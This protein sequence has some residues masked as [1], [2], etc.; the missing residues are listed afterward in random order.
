[1]L[2]EGGSAIDAAIAA[3]FC[4][5][6]AMPQS[7]GLGGGFVMMIYSKKNK[8]VNSLTARETAP[9]K[10]TEDMFGGN[11]SVSSKGEYPAMLDS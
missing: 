7:C 6:V 4:E 11:G 5:G 10:A 1:M 9:L 2:L 8:T 3:L